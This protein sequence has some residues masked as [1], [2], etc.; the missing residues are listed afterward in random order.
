M[1]DLSQIKLVLFFTRDV[2]LKTWGDVGMLDREIA[3]YRLMCRHMKDVTFVTYGGASDLHY[4]RR[5]DCISTVCNKWNLPEWLYILLISRV[6]PSLWRG[7]VVVKSNQ[8]QGAD[9][10]LRAALHSGKRFIARCGYLYSEFMERQHGVDSAEA[11]R[12]RAF[13]Q[14]IFTAADRVVVTAVPMRRAVIQR[15]QVPVERV[16]VIPNYVQTDLFRPNSNTPSHPMRICFVGR[17]DEQKNPFALLRA[18]KGLD[19]ELLIV[20]TGSLENRLRTEA[21]VDR[22]PVRFLGNVP[23]SQLPEVLN[24]STLFVL[25]SHYEGHPKTLLEAMACGVPVI[26]T[27][28]TGI[29]ELIAH[30][31]TG[32]LCDTS[33]EGIST[34]IQDVLADADLRA[35]M[36]R[37]ARE[38]VVE[39]F[40]LEKIV[41]MELA[42]LEELVE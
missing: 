4:A 3:L 18:I 25:P 14:K 22:L 12:A 40:A 41:K 7:A 9:I 13:E 19:V 24:S 10:A 5:L 23:H 20:G 34:A 11:R 30:G 26:G 16:K 35:R 8:V 21:K 33:P 17:L 28:V 27:N 42:L 36:G 38:F 6:Y 1:T 31:E 39:H 37:N 32:Y 2:S 29:R 15:Y